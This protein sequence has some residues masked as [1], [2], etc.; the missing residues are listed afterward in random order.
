MVSKEWLQKPPSPANA[1]RSNKVQALQRSGG[2]LIY[3]T[4][5][6]QACG[7]LSAFHRKSRTYIQINYAQTRKNYLWCS[8][9]FALCGEWTYTARNTSIT[10]SGLVKPLYRPCSFRPT[11]TTTIASYYTK[12]VLQG[13]RSTVKWS[14]NS[15]TV[16]LFRIWIQIES[17]KNY[18]YWFLIYIRFLDTVIT[19]SYFN[20]S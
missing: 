7:S 1:P 18:N 11:L 19:D 13:K 17:N 15:S 9:I 5:P 6:Y 4:Y 8:E 14:G 2:Y 12:D 16:W 3:S 20:M 10:R